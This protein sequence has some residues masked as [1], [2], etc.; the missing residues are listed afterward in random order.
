M[1]PV[2][3]LKITQR[4]TKLSEMIP[5]T[6]LN[7]PTVFECKSGVMGST[8]KVEGVPFVTQTNVY[9]VCHGLSEKRKPSSVR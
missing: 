7:S 4:E 9:P 6:H 2:D 1:N 8:I 5:Y 3:S